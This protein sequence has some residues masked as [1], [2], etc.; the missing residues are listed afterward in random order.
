[1]KIVSVEIKPKASS[2][3]LLP[4]EEMCGPLPAVHATFEDG[5]VEQLFTYYPDE[6]SFSEAEFVGLTR[7]QA[8]KLREDKD[9]SYLLS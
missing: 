2:S 5:S 3:K 6:I 9:M 8:I 1:M 4:F 7:E